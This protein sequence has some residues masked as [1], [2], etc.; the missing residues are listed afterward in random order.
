[1]LGFVRE[2]GDAAIDNEQ[3]VINTDG[4]KARQTYEDILQMPSTSSKATDQTRATVVVPRRTKRRRKSPFDEAAFFSAATNGDLDA[5]QH[6]HIGATNANRTDTFGWS[7]LMMAAFAGHL[8]C[9][10]LL[11]CSGARQAHADKH[12]NT[13]ETLADKEHRTDVVEYLRALDRAAHDVICLSSGDEDGGAADSANT[14]HCAQCALEYKQ[15]D[16]VA[17]KTSTLHRFNGDT[18]ETTIRGFGIPESNVGYQMMVKQGW[19][20]QHGLGCAKH[21]TLFP[22]KT[23]LRKPRSGL[24]IKQ[25]TTARVTHFQAHDEA[26]VRRPHQPRP[27]H[28]VKTKRQIQREKERSQR[29]DRYLRR[30]LS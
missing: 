27:I 17:H 18:S 16:Q 15:K 29:K 22:V 19:S 24:G 7:A 26:A 9:V 30:L 13:A 5:L 23:V 8:D 21:G 4:I 28:A 1:M 2:T 20:G 6:M 14:I 3:S 12:G 25:P 10:R 11:I